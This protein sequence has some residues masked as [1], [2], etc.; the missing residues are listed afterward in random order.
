MSEPDAVPPVACN[1]V[2][3]EHG[4]GG[5]S[6]FACLKPPGHKDLHEGVWGRTW[7]DLDEWESK[8]AKARLV[9]GEPT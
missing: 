7:D 9:E 3:T 4:N 2:L 8:P 1:S 6:V 5:P